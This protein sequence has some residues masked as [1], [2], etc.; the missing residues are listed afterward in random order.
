MKYCDV[1]FTTQPDKRRKCLHCGKKL[2]P[3]PRFS[4][5]LFS[6]V[7]KLVQETK[8]KVRKCGATNHAAAGDLLIGQD[9]PICV[10]HGW[11]AYIFLHKLVKK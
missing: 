9:C 10:K 1:C 8:K 7:K 3:V 2:L 4:G 11:D 6:L 5:K